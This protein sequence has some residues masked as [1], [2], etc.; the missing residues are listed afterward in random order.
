MQ[1][2]AKTVA[3]YLKE[4]PPERRKPI[5]A[6]RDVMRKNLPKGFEE[7]MQYGM[8]GYFVP[9]SLYPDGYHCD[10]KQPLPYAHLASQKNY[11]SIYM[12]AVYSAEEHR[13]W[14]VKAWTG[15]GKKLDMGKSCVRFKNIDDVPLDVVG[16]AMKCATPKQFIKYYESTIQG[17]R[18]ATKK[19]TRKKA[20][21][22]RK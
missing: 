12:M 20:A 15:A 18:K 9:H 13:E 17:S 14:F 4:L 10:P 19:T 16:K 6:I 1:S 11:M 3:Q 7:G 8:I 2:Q 21:K 5:S 22:K